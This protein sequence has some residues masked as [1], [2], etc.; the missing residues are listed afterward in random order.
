MK[1]IAIAA[2]AAGTVDAQCDKKLTF[3]T[4]VDSKCETEIGQDV[5]EA[6]EAKKLTSCQMKDRK[7]FGVS[8]SNYDLSMKSKCTRTQLSMKFFKN[9][10]CEGFADHTSTFQYNKCLVYKRGNPYMADS[11]P[12]YIKVTKAYYALQVGTVAALAFAGSQF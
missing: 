4:F 12:I 11:D 5:I 8:A 9:D 2:L 10:K 7:F 1:A 6:A 3:T